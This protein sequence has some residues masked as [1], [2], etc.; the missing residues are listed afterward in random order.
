MQS[1]N[2]RRTAFNSTLCILHSALGLGT[3]GGNR[4]HNPR[5][6]RPVLYPLSYGRMVHSLPRP[7]TGRKTDA[8]TGWSRASD[9]TK[10]TLGS[11]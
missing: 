11:L 9:A 2:Y 6:R 7:L 10:Y 3:P 8:Q 5:L 1:A 4:T